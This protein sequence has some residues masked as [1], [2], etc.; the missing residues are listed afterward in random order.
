MIAEELD[1]VIEK[2]GA[3]A[4]DNAIIAYEP[5]WA[6]GTGKCATPEQAQEVHSFIR[7]RLAEDTPV[8]GEKVRIIYGGSVT[9]ANA[10]DLFAQSDIDGGLIGRASLD[11]EAFLGIVEAAKGAS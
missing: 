11:G 7:S 2:N 3:M 4:F 8:I 9:P 1:I 10:Q 5:I 6:V